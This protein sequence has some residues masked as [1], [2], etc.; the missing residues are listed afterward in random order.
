MGLILLLVAGT[1]G[2]IFLI[3]GVARGIREDFSQGSAA[4]RNVW[5]GAALLLIGF[6]IPTAIMLSYLI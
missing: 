6:G 4:R 1:V 5:A 3:D 2:A